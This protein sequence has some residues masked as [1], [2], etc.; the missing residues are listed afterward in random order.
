MSSLDGSL[1]TY[2]TLTSTL[3]RT[4]KD[5]AASRLPARMLAQGL[6]DDENRW[7]VSAILASRDSVVAAIGGRV[8][9][10]RIEEAEVKKRKGKGASGKMSARGERV[11]CE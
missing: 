11:R 8:L 7:K 1:R 2:D 3:L 9:A 5:R 10:W 6:I 4:F